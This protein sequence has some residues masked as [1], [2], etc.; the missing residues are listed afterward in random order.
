MMKTESKIRL[1][2]I[3]VLVIFSC[4]LGRID[5]TLVSVIVVII[6]GLTIVGIIKLWKLFF[7]EKKEELKETGLPQKSRQVE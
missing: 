2:I 4:F 6:F 1:S 3:V 7:K 5:E